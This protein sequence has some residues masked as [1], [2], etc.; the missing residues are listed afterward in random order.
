[1]HQHHRITHTQVIHAP[2]EK[3]WAALTEAQW[4]K[5]YFFGTELVTTWQVGSPIV[6]QGAWEGQT[7][8]DQGT[9]I[10]Y[11]DR[12]RLAFSYLSSWSG[13]EDQ[14][15]NYLWVCYELEAQGPDTVVTIHQTNYDAE[16]AAHSAQN[17]KQLMEAM[18]ALIE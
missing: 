9:V 18:A 16:K 3:V 14:P 7:Y 5:Q 17:W 13:L 2:V 4:V 1:M 10:E 11:E 8:K 15:E 6:F 12:K